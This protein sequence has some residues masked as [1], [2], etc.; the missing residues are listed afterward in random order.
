MM[1][2]FGAAYAKV[3]LVEVVEVVVYRLSGVDVVRL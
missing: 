2:R 1:L 3:G